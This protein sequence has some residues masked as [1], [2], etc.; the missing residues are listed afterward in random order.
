MMQLSTFGGGPGNLDFEKFAAQLPAKP[1]TGMSL[2]KTVSENATRERVKIVRQVFMAD[3]I[4]QLR[5]MS[6]S[7]PLNLIL[8]HLV[9]N[10]R[11]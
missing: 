5:E 6:R 11:G 7:F 3:I 10:Q 8:D 2:A 9:E 1:P 4:I